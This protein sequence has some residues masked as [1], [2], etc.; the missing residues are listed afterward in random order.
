MQPLSQNCVGLS[1]VAKKLCYL[2]RNYL[3]TQNATRNFQPK[4]G[5]LN[6]KRWKIHLLFYIDLTLMKAKQEAII[7]GCV[8]CYYPSVIKSITQE[9]MV[10]W[11]TQHTWLKW[12]VYIFWLGRGKLSRRY[13]KV[14]VEDNSK[15]RLKRM[16]KEQFLMCK[17]H[18]PD[19]GRNPN[20]ESC[21]RGSSMRGEI[22]W[23]AG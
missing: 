15:R 14:G 16:L 4:I 9:T 22:T 7:H 17:V 5:E 11:G 18:S 12:E 10:L 23:T 20:T 2:Y 6:Y 13:A 3:I 19:I 8:S 21:E 1:Q